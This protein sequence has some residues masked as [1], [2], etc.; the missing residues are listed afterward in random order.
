[1]LL[2]R[3]RLLIQDSSFDLGVKMFA[4][5]FRYLFRSVQLID[6]YSDRF[7]VVK[8]S[9]SFSKRNTARFA[10]KTTS[11]IVP[12]GQVVR[13]GRQVPGEEAQEERDPR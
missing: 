6:I 4:Q 8:K 9:R 7:R 12:G 1:M 13:E 11:S 10:N 3:V 2:L 5:E